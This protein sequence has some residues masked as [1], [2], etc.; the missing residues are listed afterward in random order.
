MSAIRNR[1]GLMDYKSD[2]AT[3]AQSVIMKL[4]SENLTLC[5][6]ES[7]TCGMIASM[8]GAVAGASEVF[9]G[10]VVSYS[11]EVKKSL[12]GV[13]GTTIDKYGVV[14]EE[15]AAEMAAGAA[16]VTA[17]DIAVSVTGLAGPGGGTPELPVGTVCFGLYR[18][19]RVYT[20]TAHFEKE[21]DR[22]TIRALASVRALELCV[23][24]GL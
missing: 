15:V 22:Q 12:L 7:C 20:E 2:I 16:R 3:P 17:A 24:K 4:R 9:L 6:A 10:G 11:P 14:S 21:L 23:T 5:C 18:G 13:K 19:G 8:I 1:E